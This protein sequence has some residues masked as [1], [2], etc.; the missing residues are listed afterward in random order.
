MP[1]LPTDKVY[2]GTN[3]KVMQNSRGTPHKMSNIERIINKTLLA[4]VLAQCALV[5]TVDVAREFWVEQFLADKSKFWYLFPEG[6]KTSDETTLPSIVANWLTF[7]ILFNNFVP[8]NLYV[9]YDMC[10]LL[11]G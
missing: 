11:Q 7:F 10:N 2:T 9:V 4:V 5:T 6:D 8:I 1:P 3:T